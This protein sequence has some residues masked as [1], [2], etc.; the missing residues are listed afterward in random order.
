[1]AS[2]V[3]FKNHLLRFQKFHNCYYGIRH[4]ESKANVGG[5]IA[6]NI[7]TQTHVGLTEL[8]QKQV[9]LASKQYFHFFKSSP[10]IISSDFCRTRETA[11]VLMRNLPDVGIEYIENI[12][13]RERFFGEYDGLSANFYEP[14]WNEGIDYSEKGI[15]SVNSVLDRTTSLILDLEHQYVNRSIFLVSHGDPLLILEAG[16]KQMEVSRFRELK[17]FDNAEIRELI[18]SQCPNG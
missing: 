9:L 15:E 16:I 12:E 1:M 3:N 7:K 6:S 2:N 11:Q 13:L 5:Y 18:V 14:V 10:L 17:Y 8:G 4:A